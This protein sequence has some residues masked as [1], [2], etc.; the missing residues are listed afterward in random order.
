MI[1]HIEFPNNLVT[2]SLT[3]Q[4]NI[5]C[6][7]QISDKF[8]IIF[9]VVFPQ[10]IGNVLLWDRKILEER[11]IAR[12]SGAYTH[13]EPALI[14]LSENSENCYEITNLS[15]F[16]NDFGWCPIIDNSEYAMPTQFW[17]SNDDD[18]GYL[19]LK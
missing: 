11:A 3:K 14:T 12:A 2:G 18:P 1:L 8:E 17:D 6:T 5:P 7:I 9:S 4:K 15:V 13:N 19:P 16:Y 10:T